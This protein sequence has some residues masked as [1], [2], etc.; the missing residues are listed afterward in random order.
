MEAR[1]LQAAAVAAKSPSRD[2]A[3]S[4]LAG[5]FGPILPS[6]QKRLAAGSPV[7]EQ[8]GHPRGQ[9]AQPGCPCLP[10]AVQL[11]RGLLVVS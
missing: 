9:V 11:M 5:H 10:R 4:D 1:Q 6:A 2:P 7:W 3:P 8:G